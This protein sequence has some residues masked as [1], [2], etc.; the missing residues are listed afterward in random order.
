MCLFL[1]VPLLKK[2]EILSFTLTLKGPLTGGG[3][4]AGSGLLLGGR[5]GPGEQVLH[6]CHHP[7][8]PVPVCR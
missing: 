3:W 7:Q 4:E 1:S 6:H 5:T 8:T 2:L